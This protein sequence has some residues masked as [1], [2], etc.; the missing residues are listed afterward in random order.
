MTTK[1]KTG[2]QANWYV[3]MMEKFDLIVGKHAIPQEI[4]SDLQ[5]LFVE[6]ARE[7]YKSGN[8]S[9]ISWLLKEQAKKA[10][11]SAT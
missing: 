11:M 8:K 10:A 6:T 3:S 2:V 1:F 5:S 7:Q 9:G 4:S